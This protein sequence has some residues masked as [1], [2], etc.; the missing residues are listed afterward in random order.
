MVKARRSLISVLTLNQ[1]GKRV[2]TALLRHDIGEY[3]T[4]KK[5]RP[6]GK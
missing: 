6:A 4:R 5:E 2:K 1:P 3:S